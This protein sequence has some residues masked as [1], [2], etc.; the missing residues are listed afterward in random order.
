[1]QNHWPVPETAHDFL[2]FPETA[3]LILSFPETAL[4]I[5]S[6]PE[7]APLVSRNGAAPQEI[8]PASIRQ[9]HT[10]IHA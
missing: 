8:S 7:T 3:L 5:L 10:A 9:T 6:F 4:L 1:M 2:S